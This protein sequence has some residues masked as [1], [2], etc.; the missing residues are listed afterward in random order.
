MS[1]DFSPQATR[2]DLRNHLTIWAT[3]VVFLTLGQIAATAFVPRSLSL[4][5][6]NDVIE[7]L[8]MLSALL[9][10]LVNASAS[11]RPTRLFWMLLA[12]GWGV[13]IVAQAMWMYFDLVLRKE[14][15][16]P[17]V[18]D[19][20][21]FLCNIPFLAA[22]LLQPHLDPVKGRESKGTVDFLLLL[23]WWL[24][25]YLFF[26]VPWQYVVRD[27]AKYGFNYNRLNGLLDIVLLLTLASLWSRCL[28]RWKWF[29]AIFFA[30]QLL[31]TASGY[32]ANVAIVK[33]LYY[34]GSWYD[35]PLSLALT[36]FTL[37]GLFGFTL[38]GVPAAARKSQTLV[39][40]TRLGMLAVLS[41]PVMGAWAVLNRNSP[42]P[43]TRF[44][45]LVTGGIM[46]VMTSLVF[47]KLHRMRMELAKANRVLQETSATDPLTGARN[48]RFFDTTI[49][50]DANQALR[51]YRV[52][53]LR[54]SDLIFY[55]V[56]LDDFKEVNDR[57]GHGVGDQVLLEVT[58]RINSVIR[59]SD[60]LVRWGGDEFLIVSRY[61]NRAEAATFALRILT[62]VGNREADNGDA[63]IDL[64][65][66]CSIG[67]AAFPW[68]PREPDAVPLETV[69]GLAD[70]GVY[71]AKTFGKNRAIGVLL[72][73]KGT[74]VLFATAGDRVSTYCVQTVCVAGPSQPSHRRPVTV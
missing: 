59:S 58:R 56:D 53:E 4:T 29:Y 1:P 39:P 11:P 48:R 26:V 2:P 55:M 7:F 18:G 37:V 74:E 30:A 10:F 31:I 15:P 41:L 28:G 64:H 62:A 3:L 33:H 67:W 60:V 23:L 42:A 63:G 69:L 27:E 54:V 34:P 57:Y 50:G 40:V 68:D 19:I 70:R 32:V 8:L 43:V 9:V 25:L 5:L 21:L 71:E 61:S 44:R 22:L 72:S 13:T 46:L 38:A 52:Q 36:A 49:A 66:T 12:A 17:F 6:I 51:S 73:D 20:L 24:N 16:N 14:A 47:A 35:V 45:E 65:Q